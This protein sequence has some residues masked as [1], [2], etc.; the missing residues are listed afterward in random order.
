MSKIT[1]NITTKQDKDSQAKSTQFTVDFTGMTEQ[2]YQAMAMA[3]LTVKRQGFY[4]VHGIPATETIMAIGYV[5]GTRFVDNRTPIEKA[6]DAL[7]ALSP[8]EQ[9]E[10][11]K[12]NQAKKAA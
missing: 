11:V 4:R 3:F 6:R 5:P 2:Q 12:Q 8:V 7:A 9:A 1:H 10:L